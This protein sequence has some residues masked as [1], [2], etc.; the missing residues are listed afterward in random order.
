M[1]LQI[2]LRQGR[3]GLVATTAIAAF[4]GIAQS[5]GYAAIAGHSPATRAA[6]AA[7]MELV[8]RQLT[9]LLPV[10]A[11]VETVAGFL[12]WRHFGTLPLVYGVWA[13]L[14][15]AGAARGDEERGHVE[16]WLAAGLSRAR[17][18]VSRVAV[19]ALLATVSAAVTC[20]ATLLGTA[21]AG[22]AL[23]LAGL[24]AQGIALVALSVCCYAIAL[25]V[26]QFAVTGRTAAGIGAAVLGA[27]FLI[28]GAARSG[29]F[30]G[31]A[32]L[33][34]FWQ[35]ERSRPLI[36]GGSLDPTSVMWLFGV[37][38]LGTAGAVVLFARR[39]LGSSALP[40]RVSRAAAVRD[41]ARRI[42]LRLPVI[43][44]IDRQA[45]G[46]I[47]WSIGLS[48]LGIFLGSLLPTMIRLAKEVPIIRVIVL[49]GGSG[50]LDAA[51]VG[52]VWGSS[53]L[54]VLSSYVI[55]QVAAWAADESEGRLEMALSAPIPRWRIVLERIA[56]LT[57]GA[58]FL[59]LVASV[60]VGTATRAQGLSVDLAKF[61]AASALLVPLVVTCGAIGAVLIGW[62]PRAA[63]WLL[64]LV[65]VASYFIQ[66]LAPMFGFNDLIRHLSLFELYGTPLLDGPNWRGL[67]IQVAI[68]AVGFGTAL[69]SMSRR[70]I[71]R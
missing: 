15:A 66:Q 13:L 7:Q 61:A 65:I 49:R 3:G 18:L 8:G 27:L 43:A 29:G 56:T 32:P 63:L 14:A 47:A 39:D 45:T 57:V 68:I 20:G 44:G 36:T 2:A 37:A 35:Y 31:V 33:S 4:N 71:A 19:F 70:D 34:P 11:Q 42:T 25:V 53:A 23:P 69:F 38:L 55:A 40:R 12:Q 21:W 22:D 24:V 6:F 62:R 28:A 54:L 9:F 1:M 59:V 50:D 60:I 67:A 52:A 26:T 5:L 46:L 41:P 10:P 16:Q 58:S 17:Y 64:G 51:F 30:E 48:A